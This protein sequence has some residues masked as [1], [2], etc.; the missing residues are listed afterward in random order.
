MRAGGGG[1]EWA[2]RTH[3]SKGL[4][5]T[6]SCACQSPIPSALPFRSLQTCTVRRKMSQ[7][8]QKWG[9]SQQRLTIPH[10]RPS[11]VSAV[12]NWAAAKGEPLIYCMCEVGEPAFQHHLKLMYFSAYVFRPVAL[13]SG[14]VKKNKPLVSQCLAQEISNPTDLGRYDS[15]A[16]EG[17]RPYMS[18]WEKF[19]QRVCP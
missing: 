3:H 14:H 8:V 18:T 11:A 4:E 19:Q 5:N 16:T 2:L 15:W 9:F 13:K 6:A 7:E 10:W 1:T 17:P 12:T